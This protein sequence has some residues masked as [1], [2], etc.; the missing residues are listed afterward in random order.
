MPTSRTTG[1]LNISQSRPLDLFTAS[2]SVHFP[3]LVLQ[4]PAHRRKTSIEK[5]EKHKQLWREDLLTQAIGFSLTLS[6]PLDAG[7]DGGGSF[8]P[9]PPLAPS[10]PKRERKLSAMKKSISGKILTSPPPRTAADQGGSM[11]ARPPLPTTPEIH[12]R[13]ALPTMRKSL[14]VP[15]HSDELQ[16]SDDSRTSS[17]Y[18]I[19][20]NHSTSPPP[21][22]L[23]H[24]LNPAS[25]SSPRLS[26]SLG[27][28][29]L[30]IPRSTS[31]ELPYYTSP[32][33]DFD[34]SGFEQPIEAD[35]RYSVATN[36]SLQDP[37][38]VLIS[39]QSSSS[40]ASEYSAQD[41]ATDSENG[42]LGIPGMVAGIGLGLEMRGVSPDRGTL[43]QRSRENSWKGSVIAEETE[44]S[45]TGGEESDSSQSTQVK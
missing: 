3:P 16:Y 38:E 26:S 4:R 41:Y 32:P 27:A 44:E 37:V 15:L 14:Q 17:V 5:V 43:G 12:D 36:F 42:M 33:G 34:P 39:E 31:S 24:L 2:P 21:A 29:T 18:S 8:L 40:V 28:Q 11:G 10:S 13:R 23:S 35:S 9:S 6:P 7:A 19:S 1:G 22:E 45:G 20:W 25:P 30:A